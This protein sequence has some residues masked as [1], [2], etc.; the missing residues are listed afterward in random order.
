MCS[1]RI[2]V[3]PEAQTGELREIEESAAGIVAL[4]DTVKRGRLFA[5]V[6]S[7]ER[8]PVPGDSYCGVTPETIDCVNV[9]IEIT[10]V[11]ADTWAFDDD[12]FDVTGFDRESYVDIGAGIPSVRYKRRDY[13]LQSGERL[14]ASIPRRVPRDPDE[15][16]L[17]YRGEES[18]SFSLRSGEEW[19]SESGDVVTSADG[20]TKVVLEHLV[21]CGLEFV[22]VE[23]VTRDI[24]GTNLGHQDE[25]ARCDP[26]AVTVSEED[27]EVLRGEVDSDF[28]RL[29]APVPYR[30]TYKDA[31]QTFRVVAVSRGVEGERCGN[32]YAPEVQVCVAVEFEITNL[33]ASDRR[34]Y[35]PYTQQLSY[36]NP[37]FELVGTSGVAYS[38][39]ASDPG[40]SPYGEDYIKVYPGKR[41]TT[42]IVRYVRTHEEAELLVYSHRDRQLAFRLVEDSPS[43]T[44]SDATGSR[45][46][47][48]S[49]GGSMERAAPLGEAVFI[50]GLVVKIAEVERGWLPDDDCCSDPIPDMLFLREEDN[51]LRSANS[52]SDGFFLNYRSP[53][54]KLVREETEYVRVVIEAESVVPI[55][56]S[57]DFDTGRIFL[58]D[59]DRRIFARSFYPQSENQ[60][61]IGRGHLPPLRT[62]LFLRQ[63]SRSAS[64]YGGGKAT[65]E[66][67]WM[68]PKNARGLTAV[69]VPYEFEIGAFLALE[70]TAPP[71]QVV[72]AAVPQWIEAAVPAANSSPTN[73]VPIG[74]GARYAPGFAV[75]V[76]EVDRL[77]SPCAENSSPI[78]GG[79]CLDVEVEFHIEPSEFRYIMLGAA[80]FGFLKVGRETIA[81]QGLTR[82]SYMNVSP[83]FESFLDWAEIK[84]RGSLKASYKAEIDAG[85]SDGIVFFRPYHRFPAAFLSIETS[86]IEPTTDVSSSDDLEVDR[87]EGVE[88]G[89][90][91]IGIDAYLRN[92]APVLHAEVESFIGEFAIACAAYALRPNYDQSGWVYSVLQDLRRTR[93]SEAA[94]AYG[95]NDDQ[96][97]SF[98]ACGRS[99]PKTSDLVVRNYLRGTA[100][101]MC[102]NAATGESGASSSW[103][104]KIGEVLI[105]EMSE[106]SRI[107]LRHFQDLVGICDWIVN[108]SERGFDDL[109]ATS[110]PS[111]IT[112]GEIGNRSLFATIAQQIS[113]REFHPSIFLG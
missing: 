38:E 90:I 27:L 111:E 99:F 71:P 8:G 18:M 113:R 84:E 32:G 106:E 50:Q 1:P 89:G 45:V 105:G 42:R 58:V 102:E 23:R 6:V 9:G 37:N 13:V 108:A 65:E 28:G 12:D 60:L 64:V 16:R 76:L 78:D 96:V 51:V 53:Y 54:Y 46:L 87:A 79:G 29:S 67:A 80:G 14:L 40:I 69:Y 109:A 72:E 94:P 92:E 52:A 68:I 2:S 85:W 41:L 98:E 5:R 15:L 95:I 57:V 44:P 66:M 82:E 33:K 49:A 86:T 43:D 62:F 110:D 24:G 70:R 25:V 36:S 22:Y 56:T 112:S 30:E 31:S 4:G 48:G 74:K 17:E 39:G 19:S 101:F 81:E 59:E 100:A 10:N 91:E 3:V 77:P 97:G 103:A 83:D 20:R 34:L 104:I 73:P 55:E 21:N 93:V 7:I 75:R 107:S 63:D 26:N 61:R 35:Q 47:I 88:S 11:G